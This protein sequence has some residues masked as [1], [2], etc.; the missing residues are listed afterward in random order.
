MDFRILHYDAL[1]STND[2]AIFFAREGA[3][4]GTVVATE[5]QKKGRGR[6]ERTWLSPRGKGLLFSLILRPKLRTFQ[7]PILTHWAAE[8]VLESL[9]SNYGLKA[10]LKKPND[11]LVRDK[12]I[13]GI[14]TESSA[15]K[16][17]LDYVIVG[18]G[19]NVNSTKKDLLDSATSIFMETKKKVEK[20]PLML[21][22]LE[23]FR[24]QYEKAQ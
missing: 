16:Q 3:Q 7:A 8:A 13:C 20:E 23:Y 12:K 17:K 10:K 2:Q 18:I 24:T 15:V 19:L 14:L 4:E 22:I 11:V 5:F 21:D 6:F 1:D 9:V